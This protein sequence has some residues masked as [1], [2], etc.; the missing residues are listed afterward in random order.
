MS[1]FRNPILSITPSETFHIED[2]IELTPAERIEVK[3]MQQDEQLRRK[4]PKA[5][6]A[7]IEQR[8]GACFE[9]R[10]ANLRNVLQATRP[11]NSF[12]AM[13]S[14][15]ATKRID[16]H[17]PLS[18]T[19]ASHLSST[20]PTGMDLASPSTPKTFTAVGRLPSPLS[21]SNKDMVMDSGEH[22]RLSIPAAVAS[23][24]KG[25]QKSPPGGH[26][27]PSS[28]DKTDALSKSPDQQISER[29]DALATEV[30]TL[31]RR[32]EGASPIPLEKQGS[33]PRPIQETAVI[34]FAAIMAR[35]GLEN[36]Q[37]LYADDLHQRIL[38]RSPNEGEY[39]RLVTGVKLLLD[40]DDVKPMHLLQAAI[41]ELPIP[42]KCS[43]TTQEKAVP[44][45]QERIEA[46][47]EK[48]QV[49]AKPKKPVDGMPAYLADSLGTIFRSQA[50][51]GITKAAQEIP[52][53]RPSINR[54]RKGGG[55]D[56][57]NRTHGEMK[58]L[59]EAS[60]GRKHRLPEEDIGEAKKMKR[61]TSVAPN[62]NGTE[63]SY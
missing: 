26:S 52:D 15:F 28:T 23:E 47:S 37:K 43:D 17:Q 32:T 63:G 42:N 44:Q 14:G 55:T 59:K 5:Y 22:R 4:D 35:K 11:P 57:N 21:G 53:L 12:S 19:Y 48:Q 49:K 50:S 9:R 3:Q 16:W 2:D 40:R 18:G 29:I 58:E 10:E 56:L 33:I 30:A 41:N 20:A 6:M 61:A 51:S 8:R 31:F 46:D 13:L 1:T 27:F 54:H 7:R 24:E 39:R 45:S 62:F 60:A 34:D 38:L 25:I 36:V